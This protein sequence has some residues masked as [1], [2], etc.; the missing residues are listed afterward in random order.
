MK[1][2]NRCGQEKPRE[3]FYAR[4][5]NKDGLC[6]SCKSCDKRYIK[7][8]KEKNE[9]YRLR[10]TARKKNKLAQLRVLYVE[11][12][13]DKYCV[14]CGNSDIRVLQH[15]H[16]RGEKVMG[17][18]AMVNRLW[19]WDAILKEIEKCEVRCANC[20]LIKTGERGKWWTSVAVD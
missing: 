12:M 19:S 20:H 16:V 2:C 14:D 7:S 6:G 10:E 13:S 4:A 1:T 17:V 18:A 15:D 8:W 3:E 11:F 9:E 5:A